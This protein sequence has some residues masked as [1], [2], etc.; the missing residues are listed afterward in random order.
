MP[1]FPHDKGTYLGA[2]NCLG[3]K[4]FRHKVIRPRMYLA[5]II[6]KRLFICLQEEWKGFQATAIY[7]FSMIP[8]ELKFVCITSE[9]SATL[10]KR[11]RPNHV[12]KS[13][14]NID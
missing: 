13:I 5:Q 3:D 9:K 8:L 14:N 1:Y 10:K 4:A 12:L 6:N 2:L 11:E 7:V